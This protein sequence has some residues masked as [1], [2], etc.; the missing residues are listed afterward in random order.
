M[1]CARDGGASGIVFRVIGEVEKDVVLFKTPSPDP[2]AEEAMPMAVDPP[3]TAGDEA[4]ADVTPPETLE[5]GVDVIK[6]IKKTEIELLCS[7][8][9]PVSLSESFNCYPFLT[10]R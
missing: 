3:G 7:Q 6:V 9:N 4:P 10:L 1:S 2:I 8:H 5:T